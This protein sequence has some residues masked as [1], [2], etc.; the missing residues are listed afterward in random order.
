LPRFSPTGNKAR[1]ISFAKSRAAGIFHIKLLSMNDSLFLPIIITPYKRMSDKTL[2]MVLRFIYSCMNGN[3]YFITL[4]DQTGLFGDAI[5]KYASQVALADTRDMNAQEKRREMRADIIKQTIAF[6]QAVAAVAGTNMQMFTSSGF[7]LMKTRQSITLGQAG[8][9]Y[10]T[11]GSNDNEL[12]VATDWLHGGKVYKIKY[13]I[14][15]VN[16]NSRWQMSSNSTS[17]CVIS[18]LQRGCSY[19]VQAIITGARK[20]STSTNFV[21][22]PIVQ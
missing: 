6:G 4:A 8:N 5:T 14:A 16:E 19:A 1:Y 7:P 9:L 10:V 18:G 17:R 2:L 13:A 21:I 3:S 22:S 20:Q 15:P 11:L 12:Q